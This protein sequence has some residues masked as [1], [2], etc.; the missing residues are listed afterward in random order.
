MGGSGPQF[1]IDTPVRL[2]GREVALNAACAGEGTLVVVILPATNGD[3]G[4]EPSA[5][6]P[7]GG[8]GATAA[9]RFALTGMS[10]PDEATIRA[11]VVEG[12]G[13]LRHPAFYIRY[14]WS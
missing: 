12:T 4:A 11:T 7:C 9:N 6:F 13:T 8:T 14:R 1:S 5:V 10:I 3:S 2:D